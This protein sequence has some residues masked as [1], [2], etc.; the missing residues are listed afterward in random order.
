MAR[1]EL[2]KASAAFRAVQ[3][4]YASLADQAARAIQGEV[5]API[6]PP[7]AE[8][9][10]VDGWVV[11]SGRPVWSPRDNALTESQPVRYR[12][13][14]S[15]AQSA[16][17]QALER[18]LDATE[19]HLKHAAE[20]AG[21]GSPSPEASARLQAEVA[22]YASLVEQQRRAIRD[23]AAP[24]EV[25]PAQELE[26]VDGWLVW[27]GRPVWWSGYRSGA[28]AGNGADRP[29]TRLPLPHS[30]TEARPR[31]RHLFRLPWQRTA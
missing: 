21:R 11:W 9:Q 13:T 17:T 14:P 29:A 28:E 19:A 25:P 6:V 4:Y 16:Y 1:T 7:L 27:K 18:G 8:L 2:Q 20:R 23:E 24:P 31:R 22:L 26:F 10:V 15:L 12:W 30:A 5:P 3:A